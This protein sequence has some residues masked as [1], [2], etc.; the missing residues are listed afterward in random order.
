M[1]PEMSY[2]SHSDK[3]EPEPAP[4]SFFNRLIG[5][6]FSPGETFQEIGRAPRV[7]AP[8][9][10]AMV[11]G[12]VSSYLVIERIGLRS[13]MATQLEQAVASGKMSQE[14]ADKQIQAVTNGVTET[15]IKYSIAVGGLLYPVI[16]ALIAVGICKLITMLI[17]GENRFKSLFSVTTYAV[18]AVSI[19]SS[20][21]LILLIYLKAPDDIDI[22]NPVGSN[23]AAILTMALG[24]DGLPN[25]IM[26]LGRWIDIFAIWT[27]ALLSIGYAAVSYKIKASTMGIALGCIYAL[28]ALVA[29]GVAAVR[30]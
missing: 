1:N 17:G 18:L 6:Y 7:L 16:F 2:A 9:V 12:F 29:A 24:K 28:I 20:A 14:D 11:I 8:L 26:A 3:I 13:I 5:V 21:L 25:F 23:L 30:G 19:I 10:I 22:N 27:L 15:I 4:Q